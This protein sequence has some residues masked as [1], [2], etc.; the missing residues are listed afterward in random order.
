MKTEP[1]DRE[2]QLLGLAIV[3]PVFNQLAYT[4]GCLDSLRDAGLPD[5]KILVINNGSTDGTRD[6]LAGRP[7]LKVIHN[8]ENRGCGFAW[9][10]GV[11]AAPATWTVLLNNDVLVP[12]GCI[13][14]LISFAQEGAFDVVC[15]ALRE[16]D[17][18]Y[19]WSGYAAQF[20]RSLAR[21]KRLGVA[22]GV[23]FMVQR[24]V[25][26]VLGG[27]DDDPRLGGYEDDEFFRR[28]RRRGFR[29]AITGKAFIH[30]FGSVTQKGIKAAMNRPGASL[31][32]RAYYRRKSGQTWAKRKRLQ[33]RDNLRA[34]WWVVTERLR[35]RHTLKEKRIEGRWRCG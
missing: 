11:M 12:P 20:V 32:D 16:G 26:N 6:F 3:V 24:R 33:L 10:Q 4:R 17:L 21:A 34:A 23:C 1:M 18:D 35:Y 31:G 9:N 13:E 30:H 14:G 25:F 28:A 2:A 19:D 8:A 5:S 29:L 7:E 27:F 22:H 15:P